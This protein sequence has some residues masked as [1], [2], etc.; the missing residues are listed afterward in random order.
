MDGVAAV[1]L[2]RR[3]AL[4]FVSA[5]IAFPF[6]TQPNEPTQTT[7]PGAALHVFLAWFRYNASSK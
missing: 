2:I 4:M 7:G 1:V 3:V 5:S 6:I